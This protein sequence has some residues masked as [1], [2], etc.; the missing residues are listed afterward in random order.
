[1]LAHLKPS[2][3][4]TLF[5]LNTCPSYLF[6]DNPRHVLGL[7]FKTRLNLALLHSPRGGFGSFQTR[8][9]INFVVKHPHRPAISPPRLRPGADRNPARNAHRAPGL[10]PDGRHCNGGHQETAK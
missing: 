3:L 6:V 10:F 2:L 1:M 4:K 5:N 7:V 8:Y 9:P